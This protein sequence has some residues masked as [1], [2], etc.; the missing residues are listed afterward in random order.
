MTAPPVPSTHHLLLALAGR[1]DDDLLA[2]AR[3]LVAIG[4]EPQALEILVATLV[5]DRTA[6]PA[7][8]RSEVVDLA[9]WRGL[10]LDAEALLGPAAGTLD[11]TRHVFG[12]GP[13]GADERLAELLTSPPPGSTVRVTWRLTPAGAAPGPLPHPVVLVELAGPGIA[14]EVVSYRLGAHLTRSGLPASVEAYTPADALPAYQRAALERA[15]EVVGGRVGAG[16]PG[17]AAGPGAVGP[18]AAGPGAVGPGAVGPGAVGP[19]AAGPGAAGPGAAGPGAAGPG[20]AGPGAAGPGAAGP[21]AAAGSVAAGSDGGA[22][23]GVGPVPLGEVSAARTTG[24]TTE[25][26]V[27][28]EGSVGADGSRPAHGAT[29]VSPRPSPSPRQASVDPGTRPPMPH[30]ALGRPLETSQPPA[31]F[32]PLRPRPDGGAGDPEARPAAALPDVSGSQADR[33]RPV[34]SPGPRP[35]PEGPRPP[36]GPVETVPPEDE[37]RTTPFERTRTPGS[38]RSGPTL[39]VVP[40]APG[41]EPPSGPRQAPVTRPT[42][43]VRA[44]ESLPTPAVPWPASRDESEEGDPPVLAA[45]RDPL[46]GPLREPLLDARLDRA[47]T[48]PVPVVGLTPPQ[49]PPAVGPE[50]PSSVEPDSTEPDST[51]EDRGDTADAPAGGRRRRA[52]E[53]RREPAAEWTRDWTSGAWAMPDRR[54]SSELPAAGRAAAGGE[55]SGRTAPVADPTAPRAQHT[56]TTDPTGRPQD[57]SADAGLAGSSGDVRASGPSEAPPEDGRRDGDRANPSDDAGES[58][59]SGEDGPRPEPGSCTGAPS[60]GRDGFAITSDR[61]GGEPEEGDRRRRPGQTAGA[62]DAPHPLSTADPEDPTTGRSP[63]VAHTGLPSLLGDA[64]DF[65]GAG[66]RRAAGTTAQ[67][68]PGAPDRTSGTISGT[69]DTGGRPAAPFD[70]PAGFRGGAR[71]RAP[72]APS[73]AAQ[74]D[75]DDAQDRT[76]GAPGISPDTSRGGSL[77]GDPEGSGSPGRRRA[78]DATSP[79]ERGGTEAAGDSRSGSPDAEGRMRFPFGDSAGFGGPGRRPASDPLGTGD[80]G[81]ADGPDRTNGGPEAGS[82]PGSPFG[83]AGEPRRRTEANDTFGVTGGASLPRPS[84]DTRGLPDGAGLAEANGP[85][86]NAGAPD[87]A[88]EPLGPTNGTAHPQIGRRPA[89]APAEPAERPTDTSGPAGSADPRPFPPHAPSSSPTADVDRP[90]GAA[91]EDRHADVADPTESPLRIDPFDP[92]GSDRAATGS[93]EATEPR[94]PSDTAPRPDGG[95]ATRG[96]GRPSEE[97]STPDSGSGA[98]PGPLATDHAPGPRPGA[99]PSAVDEST[100]AEAIDATA[101]PDD[102]AP[103]GRRAAKDGVPTIRPVPGGRR[104]ARHRPDDAEP[105]PWNFASDAGPTPDPA[106]G[107]GD[108]P[109]DRSEGLPP[110][111]PV[112]RTIPRIRRTSDQPVSGLFGPGEVPPSRPDDPFG[113]GP[114]PARDRADDEPHGDAED[115]PQSPVPQ[116]NGSVPET[117]SSLSSREQDLL[118]LLQ[119]ELAVRESAPER[120][121]G[122]GPYGPPDL[123]G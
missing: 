68:D 11:G 121:N 123:P 122:S 83:D 18:G 23:P 50:V 100:G 43:V 89:V 84:N 110:P 69:P 48:G 67:G 9:R 16:G 41:H 95:S 22:G 27:P 40:A 60:A 112:P 98:S 31:A 64:A 107:S 1:V 8:L 21:G 88:V 92:L 79:A 5:A 2:T 113:A 108:G 10:E 78:A 77:L 3:E 106:P 93:N 45:M 20:A 75:A 85:P 102:D 29:D 36:L 111:R 109:S 35:A 46:S 104:R 55:G 96:V 25:A 120:R 28:G 72:E 38:R 57:G 42:P 34:P 99:D 114:G 74:G 71:R 65:G 86:G 103:T 115:A 4:E 94:G 12:A 62:P 47:E 32:R 90:A 51:G 59:K 39:S 118:R 66:R 24:P 19:G 73:T 117:Y 26:G 7:P 54:P 58:G 81:D 76:G 44:D 82:R 53:P 116:E 49:G 87:R 15:R 30:P 13:A 33:P 119:Q 105:D 61:P 6:L 70:D 80:R 97:D 91:A 63:S 17:A 14:P 101:A 52:E 37:P 56:D